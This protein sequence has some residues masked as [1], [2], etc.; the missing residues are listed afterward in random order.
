VERGVGH[1][2]VQRA[3]AR[4]V[5]RPGRGGTPTGVCAAFKQ[6]HLLPAALSA[7]APSSGICEDTKVQSQNLNG[8]RSRAQGCEASTDLQNPGPRQGLRPGEWITPTPSRIL[9]ASCA[10]KRSA[11]CRLLL[12][13]SGG[14]WRSTRALPCAAC[15]SRRA[16]LLLGAVM[17]HEPPPAA[18]F[19]ESCSLPIPEI[20]A[21]GGQS[22]GKSSLLEAFLGVCA[23]ARSG[24][25]TACLQRCQPDS[26]ARH[27]W[28]LPHAC[29]LAQ[30]TVAHALPWRSPPPRL[31]SPGPRPQSSLSP[32]P[33]PNRPLPVPL[34]RA[35]GGDGHAPPP[36]RP[37]GPRPGGAAAAVPA[38]GGGR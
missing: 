24:R 33:P 26:G 12:S 18:A 10:M 8:A 5:R 25:C 2:R 30:R 31:A 22:D 20:V 9:P 37:D 16:W 14:A 27:S 34:Q 4:P 38:A 13:V 29:R 35:R 19:G 32:L 21:I 6:V 23:R 11:G 1:S 17:T 3:W 36:D 15:A 7:Q 28:A